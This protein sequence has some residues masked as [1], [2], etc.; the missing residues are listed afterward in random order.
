MI[1]LRNN[2]LIYP[3]CDEAKPDCTRC[4]QG[5]REVSPIFAPNSATSTDGVEVQVARGYSYA[6]KAS[7]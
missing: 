6:E 7:S 3:Q 1:F 5:Q 4:Q 2:V